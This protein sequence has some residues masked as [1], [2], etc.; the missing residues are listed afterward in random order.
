[1]SETIRYYSDDIDSFPTAV[2][3]IDSYSLSRTALA[4]Q[5]PHWE[6][7]LGTSVE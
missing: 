4:L 5:P 6:K 1:M 3:E 7:L 2:I